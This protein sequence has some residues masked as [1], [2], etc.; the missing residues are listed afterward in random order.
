MIVAHWLWL[1]SSGS[2]KIKL[3][4]VAILYSNTYLYIYMHILYATGPVIVAKHINTLTHTYW[5]THIPYTYTLYN[6][7]VCTCTIPLFTAG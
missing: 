3:E 1:I 2:V 4:Y 5:Y 7:N 6:T